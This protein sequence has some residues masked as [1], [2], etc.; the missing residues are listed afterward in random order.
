M[1]QTPSLRKALTKIR[2]AVAR[3]QGLCCI[4]GDVGM[5][6]SSLLRSLLSGYSADENCLVAFLPSGDLPSSFAFVKK[7]SME[8]GIPPQRSRL[9]QMDAIEE[10]LIEQHTAGKTTVIMID[11]AQLLSLDYLELYMEIH[12]RSDSGVN[13]T[14]KVHLRRQNGDWR[15]TSKTSRPMESPVEHGIAGR[16]FEVGED[17]RVF[18]GQFRRAVEIPVAREG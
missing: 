7:L 3:K 13:T 11:E 12:R 9:A 17:N 14:T 10:F 2:T 4:F 6:K 5:G 18:V 15:S 8:L 1:Y 16:I